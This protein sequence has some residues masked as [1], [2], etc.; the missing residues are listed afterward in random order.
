MMLSRGLVTTFVIFYIRAKIYIRAK[1]KSCIQTKRQE[2]AQLRRLQ[3]D[4][5]RKLIKSASHL[6]CFPSMLVSPP[7]TNF[8]TSYYGDWHIF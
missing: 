4:T 8:N 2:D 5:E 6:R 3:R 7:Y 1:R